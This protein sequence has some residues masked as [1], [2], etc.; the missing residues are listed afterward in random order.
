MRT[1]FRTLGVLWILI[2]ATALLSPALQGNW[3]VVIIL[4]FVLVP[5]TFAGLWLMGSF[6]RISMDGEEP[7]WAVIA[8]FGRPKVALR[9]G[10]YFRP[11]HLFEQVAR[12]PTGQKTMW[13]TTT[14]AWTKEQ[15]NRQA[16]PL[17]VD[18]ALYFRWPDPEKDYDFGGTTGWKRGSAL[19]LDAYYYLPRALRNPDR[20]DYV[21][22]LGR[23]LE[24][25]VIGGTKVVIGRRHHLHAR[26]E[27]QAMETEIKDYL[28]SEPG[29]PFRDLGIPPDCFDIELPRVVFPADTAQALRNTELA[30]REGEAKVEAAKHRKKA[31]EDDAA[32]IER[33]LKAYI[34]RGVSPEVAALAVSGTR[35]G[36]GWSMENLR[37]IAIAKALGRF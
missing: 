10:I 20:P 27:N 28:L 31:S 21:D 23:F 24:R 32:T 36:Q 19:L 11:L 5:L 7:Y 34:D 22:V 13:F 29:N 14:E 12:F 26:Q 6:V 2:V 33:M 4:L 35:E 15:G 9:P 25:A 8:Q 30:R 17:A 1:I 16:Q 3:G 18:I 37:D